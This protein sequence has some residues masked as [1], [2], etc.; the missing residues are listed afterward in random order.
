MWDYKP[1]ANL[2]EKYRRIDRAWDL[3]IPASLCMCMQRIR[4]FTGIQRRNSKYADKGF[5]HLAISN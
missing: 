4:L 1:S 5:I 2:S 3:E